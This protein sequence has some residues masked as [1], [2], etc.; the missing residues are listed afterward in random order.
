MSNI[1]VKKKRTFIAL[2][3][4][5]SWEPCTKKII[6]TRKLWSDQIERSAVSSKIIRAI[7]VS[8]SKTIPSKHLNLVITP[9]LLYTKWHRKG[10]LK[11]Y[12]CLNLLQKQKPGNISALNNQRISGH[13]PGKTLLLCGLWELSYNNEVQRERERDRGGDGFEEGRKFET[14]VDSSSTLVVQQWH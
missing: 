5:R 4:R 8:F 9:C 14:C 12:G 11:W 13:E 6:L 1:R 3:M 7:S 2:L 10:P